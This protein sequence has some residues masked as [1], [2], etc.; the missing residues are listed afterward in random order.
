M[1]EY[2][3]E[4]SP[5]LLLPREETERGR[6]ENVY[7]N[8]STNSLTAAVIFSKAVLISPRGR[9][10][11]RGHHA[12]PIR[13]NFRTTVNNLRSD[14]TDGVKEPEEIEASPG[15][16]DGGGGG[17]GGRATNAVI[18]IVVIVMIS[19]L[20]IPIAIVQVVHGRLCVFRRE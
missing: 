3:R 16:G 2:E 15:S 10:G 4:D 1:Q 6:S 13:T 17:G 9:R 18:T 14:G 8:R 5:P 11:K 19:N 7:N 20:V 12:V